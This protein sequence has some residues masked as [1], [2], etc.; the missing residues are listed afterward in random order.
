MKNET[1]ELAEAVQ[2]WHARRVEQ[3][4]TVLDAPAETEIRLGSGKD[5]I[6]FTGEQLRG[7]RAGMATALSFFDK[8][9]FSLERNSDEEE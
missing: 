3:V 4:N 6:V 5:A 8:L 1:L 7:F 2:A 9:P